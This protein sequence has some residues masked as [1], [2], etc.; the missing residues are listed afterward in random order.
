MD[1][2]LILGRMSGVLI[3]FGATLYCFPAYAQTAN[4]GL[5]LSGDDAVNAIEYYP[6]LLRGEDRIQL[7]LGAGGT[8]EAVVGGLSARVDSRPVRIDLDVQ[9]GAP[10]FRVNGSVEVYPIRIVGLGGYAR[11][12]RLGEG[13][14]AAALQFIPATIQGQMALSHL[15]R[16]GRGSIDLSRSNVTISPQFALE[17][18]HMNNIAR[19]I[20]VVAVVRPRVGP[21]AGMAS[22]RDGVVPVAGAAIGVDGS[23]FM[24]IPSFC[25]GQSPCMSRVGLTVSYDAVIDFIHAFEFSPNSPALVDGV[26]HRF[27]A[28]LGWRYYFNDSVSGLIRVD[29]FANWADVQTDR[30]AVVIP[31]VESGPSVYVGG[32]VGVSF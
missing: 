24:L 17:V 19:A 15:T 31:Q 25:I 14:T 30:G 29:A 6:R 20:P 8:E 32:T 12:R 13:T 1:R 10:V 26:I 18:M 5:R 23:V 16:E 2:S 28:S 7:G 27:A 9:A 22:D 4:D 3:F 11:S 21:G